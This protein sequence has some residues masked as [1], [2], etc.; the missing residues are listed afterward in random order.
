[1]DRSN[2]WN[3]PGLIWP[4]LQVTFVTA[5]VTVPSSDLIGLG[6]L[7]LTTETVQPGVGRTETEAIGWSSGMS[8]STLL[9][10]ALSSSL[11][12]RKDTLVNE[13]CSAVVGLAV[14]CAEAGTATASTVSAVAEPTASTLAI[15]DARDATGLDMAETDID[16]IKAL[17]SRVVRLLGRLVRGDV[18]PDSGTWTHG[19]HSRTHALT[20]SARHSRQSRRSPA[21]GVEAGPPGRTP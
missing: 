21:R 9:G 19:T 5:S 3:S 10:M 20:A 18:S 13:P 15:R 12:T 7:P 4:L 17:R 8:I 11:G 6:S 16:M 2:S 14:T 1:M